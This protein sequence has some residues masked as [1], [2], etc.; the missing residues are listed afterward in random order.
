MGM[1]A[2]MAE[3]SDW[4]ESANPSRAGSRAVSRPESP[5]GADKDKDRNANK[6]AVDQVRY[7]CRLCC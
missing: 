2:L 5:N 4:D 6:N 1:H 3:G 7:H